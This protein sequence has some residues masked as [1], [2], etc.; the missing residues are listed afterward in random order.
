MNQSLAAP[1]EEELANAL[2]QQGCL[3]SA[4]L[5]R[6]R[7]MRDEQG[8]ADPL[9]RL[10]IRLGMVSEKD[11]AGQ[12][13]RCFS[14]S[15]ISADDFPDEPLFE[16]RLSLR[17]LKEYH[18]LPLRQEQS[19]LYLAMADPLDSYALNAVHLATGLECKPLVG[20]S[21]DI[22]AAI[23]RLYNKEAR[24]RAARGDNDDDIAEEDVEQLKD[25]ASEAPVVRLV[26]HLFQKAVECRASDIHIEPF[27]HQLKVRYRIDGV[28]QP[29]EAP[30]VRLAQAVI[31][32]IKIM[33]RLNIAERRLPQ[34]GRIKLRSQGQE[35]DIRV[36]TVP[37]L[38]GESVV[39][40]LLRK[41]SLAL[42][43]NALGVSEDNLRTLQKVLALPDGMLLVTGPTGSGKSTTLYT[44][45]SQLNTASRKVI[46][47]E[48][49]VE[50]Q[51]AGVNQIQIKPDIGLT[52]ANALRAI[53]RQDPDVIMVGEMRDLETARICV[54][55]ALTGHLV[56][57]TLHTNDAAS[58][59]TR[60]L[61]MGVEDYLLTSTL[62]AVVGQRLV[63]LLCP[64]CKQG[65][66]PLPELV[67]QL[68]LNRLPHPEPVRL[69]RAN[70]CPQCQDTGYQGRIAIMELLVLSD[71]LKALVL[72][73]TDATSLLRQAR[74]EGML[75]MY[76]DGCIKAMAGLT[77]VEE[78]LRVTQEAG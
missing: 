26:N 9:H 17:F 39:M 65:F 52:F 4:D 7:R 70:G 19:L 21:A 27:E 36:S 23:E 78:V 47:V 71:A 3:S 57:S 69:Y 53:V 31:S 45:L 63:R 64:H 44:A 28:L 58:S 74:S 24:D 15:S 5:A 51:L 18:L 49:P 73:R 33:A 32:R 37:T 43:F 1:W 42:E 10:L 46:T 29:T 20:Q 75:T 60:L 54:Q 67:E 68:G 34:D 61:E 30:S 56:L 13:A 38:Y 72:R 76:E 55:S 48:D 16:D 66:A 59:I 40:R 62:N 35:L 2:V 22:D 6:V 12:L 8:G 41:D 77:T 11:M 50:Y 14:L 25:L